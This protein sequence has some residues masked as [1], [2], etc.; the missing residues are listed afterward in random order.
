MKRVGFAGL[1]VLLVAVLGTEASAAPPHKLQSFEARSAAESAA[2]EFQ[3]RR[4]L[5]SSTVGRCK[6]KGLRRF[7]CSASVTGE[8]PRSLTTCRL[9]IKVRAVY[10]SYYWTERAGVTKRRCT[11]E[12]TPFLPYEE[13]LRAIQVE[14]D[15]F[16][17]QSTQVTY[18]SRRDDVTFA[19]TAEW[20]RPRVPPNEF[21]PTENCSV[22]LVA[23]LTAGAVA[24]ANDGFNC[25]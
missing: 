2:F 3:M 23:T 1:M 8:G 24:V 20:S 7:V 13:A 14:A 4:K 19:G 25:Y 16:A 17:G 5:D 18:M 11:S 22:D 9:Q 6:R 10:D 21:S 12:A 15:R